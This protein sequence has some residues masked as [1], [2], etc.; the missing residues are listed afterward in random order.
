MF[1]AVHCQGL[2]APAMHV[3]YTVKYD[4]DNCKPQIRHG[5]IV[6]CL[7]ISENGVSGVLS[8]DRN[9]LVEQIR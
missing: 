1:A 9:V 8:T 6:V 2:V 7:W 3:Y 5:V 4:V